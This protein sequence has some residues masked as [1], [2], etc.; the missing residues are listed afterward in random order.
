MTDADKQRVLER[1]KGAVAFYRAQAADRK[2]AE[3][4]I[5]LNGT[6]VWPTVEAYLAATAKA[7]EDAEYVV[8]LIQQDIARGPE[9]GD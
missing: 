7:A 8:N 3:A 2:K 6:T 4:Y 9:G 1:T 5:L